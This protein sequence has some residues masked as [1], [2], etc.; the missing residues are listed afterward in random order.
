MKILATNQ[1][2]GPDPADLRLWNFYL[3]VND[4]GVT[5]LFVMFKHSN[6]TIHIFLKSRFTKPWS[7]SGRLTTFWVVFIFLPPNVDS[8]SDALWN[9]I[10]P[11]WN[12]RKWNPVLCDWLKHILKSNLYLLSTPFEKCVV[13]FKRVLAFI[14]PCCDWLTQVEYLL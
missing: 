9:W 5:R 6:L 3:D 1:D 8:N 13:V 10:K 12:R 7:L 4:H 11:P 2:Q 14:Y